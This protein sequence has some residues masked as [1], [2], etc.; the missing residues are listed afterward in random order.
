[1]RQY[2]RGK[3]VGK[4][5]TVMNLSNS[6]IPGL[7]HFQVSAPIGQCTILVLGFEAKQPPQDRMSIRKQ[8]LT[9][10]LHG[11]SSELAVNDSD[12]KEN[13]DCNDRDGYN[14]ICS[15]PVSEHQFSIFIAATEV[16][17]GF[18]YEPSPSTSLHSY[19]HIP[20]SLEGYHQYAGSSPSAY[21]DPPVCWPQQPP[22][23]SQ[24]PD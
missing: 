4:H 2:G 14:P 24:A 21:A 13:Q 17:G 8:P 10:S 16:N 23:R 15:H 20:H 6:A 12:N 18:T 22:Y 3:T 9:T 19:Q 11:C 5:R 1:M 7:Q